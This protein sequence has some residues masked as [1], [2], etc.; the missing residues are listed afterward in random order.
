MGRPLAATS[1]PQGPPLTKEVP[2]PAYQKP[3]TSP[4][5]VPLSLVLPPHTIISFQESLTEWGRPGG[6]GNTWV[7]GKGP[8][9]TFNLTSVG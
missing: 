6:K 4:W 5:P 7:C 8:G 1:H 2:F 3:M 9:A